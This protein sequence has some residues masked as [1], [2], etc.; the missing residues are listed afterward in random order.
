MKQPP[1]LP[2]SEYRQ[3]TVGQQMTRRGCTAPRPFHP[4]W[5]NSQMTAIA[6]AAMGNPWLRDQL[7]QDVNV[8]IER[9]KDGDTIRFVFTRVSEH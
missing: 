8:K 7:G 1:P 4:D 6:D 9:S 5:A 3:L 2:F